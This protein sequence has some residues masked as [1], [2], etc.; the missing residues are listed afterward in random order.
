MDSAE[1]SVQAELKVSGEKEVKAGDIETTSGVEIINKN[2]HLATLT[3]KKASLEMILTIQKGI[4]YIP[5][6]KNEE[7][8]IQLAQ[9]LWTQ[10]FSCC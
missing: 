1:D 9:L 4:G 10:F 6:E 7:G 3:D 2:L 5:V 8:A